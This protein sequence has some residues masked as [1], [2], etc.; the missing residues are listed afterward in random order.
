M[1]LIDILEAMKADL[2]G[3]DG[4]ASVGIGI[5]TAINPKLYP[6]IRIV[7]LQELPENIRSRTQ[8]DVFIGYATKPE[9]VEDSYRKLYQWADDVKSKLLDDHEHYAAFW[10]STTNDEDRLPAA[11]M[12]CIS[13]DVV[14]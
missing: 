5:E 6:A 4:I 12:I 2:A 7:P 11:K 3:I 8:V 14:Y 1:L 13:F 10:T 9:S